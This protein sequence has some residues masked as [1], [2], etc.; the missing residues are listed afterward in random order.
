[1]GLIYVKRPNRSF[2]YFHLVR[3]WCATGRHPDGFT[4]WLRPCP[5][6]PTRFLCLA[7][8]NAASAAAGVN[9]AGCHPVQ[10]ATQAGSTRRPALLISF[11]IF[12][13]ICTGSCTRYVHKGKRT[14]VQKQRSRHKVTLSLVFFFNCVFF[15]VHPVEF[16]LP[17]E[18]SVGDG[19]AR[20]HDVESRFK[21]EKLK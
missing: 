16:S 17:H 15:S 12:I 9:P 18:R 4:R 6:W 1:M 8:S 3:Q 20:I 14:K 11:S 21:N 10:L 13:V 2:I 7:P 5:G 19:N